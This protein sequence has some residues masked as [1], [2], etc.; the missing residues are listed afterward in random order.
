MAKLSRKDM[1]NAYPELD[2]ANIQYL[3]A[4]KKPH[5]DFSDK[6]TPYD[7]DLEW[8]QRCKDNSWWARGY[9]GS[10]D[11]RCKQML[12]LRDVLLSMGGCEA[13]LP[14]TDEDLVNIIAH[15]Q[16]WDNITTRMMRGLPSQC[17][18]N[19]AELWYNNRHSYK[20]GHAVIICTGY[21][22]S[23]DGIWRQHSWLVHAK[24]RA[25]V[26]IET[27]EPRVAYFGFGMTYA[28]AEQFDY[29]NP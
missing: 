25:N 2:I 23:D 11:D 4:Q 1:I 26:I 28:E 20:N 12:Q 27:T 17:H 8:E 10:L 29:D 7:G 6:I 13:C 16:L 24:P 9:T 14:V 18:S 19:S 5:I 22:L 3:I 21:A 15:G